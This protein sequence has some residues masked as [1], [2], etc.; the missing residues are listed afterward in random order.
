M[1]EMADPE[2]IRSIEDLTEAI[3][4][5]RE[6]VESNTL[7]VSSNTTQLEYLFGKMDELQTEIAKL[8]RR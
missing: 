8:T 5:L 3:N 2:L 4:K 1:K 7:K 6:V